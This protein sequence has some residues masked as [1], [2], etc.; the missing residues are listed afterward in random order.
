LV[1]GITGETAPSRRR[2][3]KIGEGG[4]R[5]LGNML[6]RIEKDFLG[7]KR[8]PE[9]VYWGIHTQ[10]ALENFP[11]SGYRMNPRLVKALAMVKKACGHA[12]LEL[13][14][15][16]EKKGE[17]ILSAC[18][19]A[20]EGKFDDQFPLDALQGGAGTSSNMNIDEVV[21]NRAIEL[22]GGKRG[23]YQLVHPIEEVNLHQSTN[24]VYPTAIRIA[25]ILL[26][27]EL[28]QA[29]ARVQGAFQKKEREFA[30]VVKVGRTELQEAVPIT[31]GAE[32]SAFGEA[33]AR[34]RWR[35]FK[36]EERLRVVNLGGTAVG[37]GLSAPRSFIFLVIE[38]LREITGLG[39]SRGENLMDATANTDPF[40]EVSGI[41]KAHASSLIKIANDLRLLHQLGEI[42]LPRVQPGSSIMPGK[43]NPV[44]PEATIQVGLKVMANDLLVTEACSRSTLQINEFLPLLAHSLLESLDILTRMDQIL[45]GH[46][47]GITVNEARC[48]EIFDQSP[49]IITAFLPHIG[50]DR[51]TELVQEFFSSGRKNVREFLSQKLSPTLVDKI[52]SP[53]KLMSLGY[54]D[55]EKNS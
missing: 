22:L 42:E 25:S 23:E 51:A 34:D 48:R 44:V 50:Y 3:V 27:R 37:T 8:V 12:N 32:F 38:K 39:L 52:L 54:R 35:T 11:I 2:G 41:L 43:V 45:A 55:D 6:Y 5:K 29:I 40:V 21:A 18:D 49:L 1:S 4:Y 36:C 10:R 24:D 28:S 14:Y 17:A 20:M 53:E 46:V 30:K 13:G 15:L 7:E 9:G 33:L 16:D 47:E 26:F 31:L 19:E